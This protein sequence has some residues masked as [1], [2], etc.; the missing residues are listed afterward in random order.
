[1]T[2]ALDR[3]SKRWGSAGLVN[4]SDPQ[5]VAAKRRRRFLKDRTRAEYVSDLHHALAQTGGQPGP[6]VRWAINGQPLGQ[7]EPTT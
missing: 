1:M 7:W 2:S 3:A 5:T 6:T 4:T